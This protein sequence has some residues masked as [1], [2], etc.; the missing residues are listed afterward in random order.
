MENIRLVTGDYN[1]RVSKNLISEWKMLRSDK[2][3]KE[4]SQD[5]NDLTYYVALEP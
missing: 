3:L 4:Y 1:V 2:W 5:V